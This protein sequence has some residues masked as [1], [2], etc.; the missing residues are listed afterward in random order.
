[1]ALVMWTLG[2][3]ISLL[4]GLVY[5]ELATITPQSGGDFT[6]IYKGVGPI[7]AFLTVWTGPLLTGSAASAV[8]AMVFADYLMAIMFGPCAS[9]QSLRKTIA[10][11]LLITIGISN[12]ISARLGVYVQVIS[13]VIKLLALG[14]IIAGGLVFLAQGRTENLKDGFE[15]SATDVT[16]YALALYSCMF[17]YGGYNRIG[18]IAEEIIDAKKNV[19]RAIVI[20]VSL[21]TCVYIAT[22][23]SYF[24]LIPKVE[25]LQSSAVAY[26]WALKGIPFIATLIPICVM[27]SVYGANNGGSF[28]IARVMFAAAR[29]D[30]YPEVFSY[31]TVSDSLPV[32][33]TIVYHTVGLL[34]LIPG[35]I[36]RLVNFLNFMAFTVMW[37]S[38]IALLRLKYMLRHEQVDPSRFRTHISIPILSL[39][40]SSFLIVAPFVTNPQIEFV[41]SAAF[42]LAGLLLYVP[43][44]HFGLKIPGIDKLTL[45]MQLLL[46]ICPTE[47]VE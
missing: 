23:V 41:Y 6:Y 43:F 29:R 45:F 15:G 8:L 27:C 14:V 10:A 44:I 30:L 20:S 39:L 12:V 32:F 33:G 46:Q 47:K 40:C 4:M 21:V 28:S 42:V 22:N 16:S 11:L 17:A 2:G 35:D 1:M 25:L 38:C 37:F 24:V 3:L 9:T 18:Y 7:P 26:D 5:C 19:P 13:S 31:L 36:G 34:M